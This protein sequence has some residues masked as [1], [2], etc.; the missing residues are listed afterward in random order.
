MTAV[1]AR[2]PARRKAISTDTWRDAC[3]API[4]TVDAL[5]ART[6]AFERTCLTARHANSRSVSS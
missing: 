3:P 2:S 6:I 5:R 1:F 4:P